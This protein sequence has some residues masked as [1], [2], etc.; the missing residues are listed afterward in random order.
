MTKEEL[1][2]WLESKGYIKD[3][4]GNYR[5]QNDFNYS[6]YRFKLNSISVRYEK[7]ISLPTYNGK[8]EHEWLRIRSGYYKDLSIND[9]NQLSG[10]R[11]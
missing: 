2:K 8:S 5:K 7:Q 10:M 9:K 3:T 1:I 6:N 4:Y 11:I